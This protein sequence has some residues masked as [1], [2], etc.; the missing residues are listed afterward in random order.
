[1]AHELVVGSQL[2]SYYIVI[3]HFYHRLVVAGVKRSKKR[4]SH[5]RTHYMH[6]IIT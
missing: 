6:T 2:V 5:S 4:H 1:M 3:L